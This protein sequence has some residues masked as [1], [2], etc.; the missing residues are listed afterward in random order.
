MSKTI[1]EMRNFDYKNVNTYSNLRLIKIFQCHTE[2]RLI[3]HKGRIEKIDSDRSIRLVY[4]YTERN[5]KKKKG[6]M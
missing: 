1:Q 2:K 4:N 3:I 6:N 5:F